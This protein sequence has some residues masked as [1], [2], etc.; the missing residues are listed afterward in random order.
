MIKILFTFEQ[1]CLAFTSMEMEGFSTDRTA[2]LPPDHACK[3]MS[4]LMG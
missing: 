4:N 3:P 1:T 2:A